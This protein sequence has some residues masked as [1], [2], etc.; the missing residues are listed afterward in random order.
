VSGK[1]YSHFGKRMKDYVYE[2]MWAGPPRLDGVCDVEDS[3]HAMIHFEGGVSLD[4][5][6]S[7][8]INM[9]TSE[10]AESETISLFGDRGGLS[11]KMTGDRVDIASEKYG[12][13]VDMRLLLTGTDKF[14]EQAR[15]FAHSVESR[16]A[17][18]ATGEHGHFVQSIIDAIYESSQTDQEIK[19]S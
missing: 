16:T 10:M 12:R 9:P 7:W 18:A 4:L 3:A 14:T 17:P 15:A 13:N 19:L 2:S 5:Q 6:V 11:F 1:V 8:A